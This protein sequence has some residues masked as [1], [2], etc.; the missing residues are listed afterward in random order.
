MNTQKA[1]RITLVESNFKAFHRRKY[2]MGEFLALV[3]NNI[4]DAKYRTI[5]K[6]RVDLLQKIKWNGRS[7]PL[8][9][10]ISNYCQ[11]VEDP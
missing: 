10:H 1:A 2:G 8:E 9:T 7:C 5:P 4:D 3:Q 11:S 6:K